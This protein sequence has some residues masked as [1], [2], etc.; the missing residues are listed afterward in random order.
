MWVDE[1]KQM[2]I[3]QKRDG[4]VLM[5]IWGVRTITSVQI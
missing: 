3:M 4:D 5:N 2:A 1:F